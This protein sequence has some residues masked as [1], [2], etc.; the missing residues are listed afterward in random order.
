MT[1]HENDILKACKRGDRKSQ[2][3]IYQKYAKAMYNTAFRMLQQSDRAEDAVQEAF[4]KAFFSLDSFRGESNF[5]AWLKRIVIN[6]ALIMLRKEQKQ[7]S[8]EETTFEICDENWQEIWDFQEEEIKILLYALSQ[9]PEKHRVILNLSI[10]EG[11]DNEEICQI[12]NISD[13]NCRT[14]LS[15]A[16]T[17]LKETIK[18]LKNE[19]NYF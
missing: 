5:G 4:I 15:R 12:L 3:A 18:H 11:F 17:I 19:R 6:E 13:G 7:V 10:I 8:I 16:K 1:N 9:L 14:S 2:T